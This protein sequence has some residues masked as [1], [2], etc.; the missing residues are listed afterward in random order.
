MERLRR[1]SKLLNLEEIAGT[2]GM[3]ATGS[4]RKAE[5]AME[6]GG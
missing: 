5:G 6:G 2:I 3:G 1:F 4:G